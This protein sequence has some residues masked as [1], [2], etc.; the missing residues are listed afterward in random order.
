VPHR[1]GIATDKETMMSIWK[2][3]VTIGGADSMEWF[4]TDD[5][6]DGL[7]A[8]DWDTVERVTIEP[9]TEDAKA[10]HLH[11]SLL[12]VTLSRDLEKDTD[13]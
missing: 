11:N 2:V 4:D 8:F 12:G 13:A 10:T 7:G 3:T 6:F 5:L 9:S 1:V